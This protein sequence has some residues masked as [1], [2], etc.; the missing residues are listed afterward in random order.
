MQQTSIW[1]SNTIKL[2]WFLSEYI[3]IEYIEHFEGISN[4]LSRAELFNVLPISISIETPFLPVCDCTIQRY[5]NR[6]PN[7]FI[8]FVSDGNKS[9]GRKVETN[10]S[11]DFWQLPLFVLLVFPQIDWKI[12]QLSS[13][14]SKVDYCFPKYKNIT[15]RKRKRKQ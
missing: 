9:F 15:K 11:H 1:N 4:S 7:L 3:Y 8:E 2:I 10:G 12:G 6:Y 5:P 14:A 13:I